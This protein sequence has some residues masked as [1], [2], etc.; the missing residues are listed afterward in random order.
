MLTS[1]T[2]ENFR[3]FQKFE[4]QQLG[5][6]NL[7]VGMNNSGKT[8]IL[9][10][11]QL[12]ASQ[13]DRTVLKNIMLN[14][15]ESIDSD[16]HSLLELDICHLFHRHQFE[17]GS[18]L[19]ISGNNLDNHPVKILLSI[20][21][22][23]TTP[24]N[25]DLKTWEL[26]IEYQ[27]EEHTNRRLSF[28]NN[29]G[30]L[31]QNIRNILPNRDPQNLQF[32]TQF[33]ASSSLDTREMIELF[34]KIVLNPAEKL[35]V[36]ALQSI[37]SRIER[38]AVIGTKKFRNRRSRDGFVVKLSDVDQRIPIGS[39]GD[40]IWRMLGLALAIVNARD[41]ILLVDEIDT[42]LHFSTMSKMWK[43]IWETAK[44]FNV[45]VFATTHNSDCWTSLAELANT[46]NPQAA[47][48]T[49][50]RIEPGQFSSIVF[51]ERQM[52]IA[53]E[54]GIEVR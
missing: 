53:A 14:R 18:E 19:S 13:G 34:E 23:D 27:G 11:V 32:N 47:G 17:L 46:D 54:R 42:G 33:V 24:E 8:S 5:R 31:V 36:E 39:M 6:I 3:C 25:E 45:Q 7:L 21:E 9:E 20:C 38:I 52:A 2:I 44:R 15:G 26:L 50:H 35:V 30:I 22:S 40:G 43:L 51:T 49:I 1:L 4:L 12:L 16:D 48:I 41:G 29:N 37:E 28:S 10:A